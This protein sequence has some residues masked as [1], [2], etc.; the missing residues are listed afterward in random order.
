MLDCFDG[1]IRL[2][3]TCEGG[4][5]VLSLQD[6]GID[7]TLLSHLK[8]SEDTTLGMLSN[9]DS[10]ARAV[11]YNDAV[12]ARMADIRSHTFVDRQRIGDPDQSQTLMT[13]TAATIGGI[14]IETAHPTSNLTIRIGMGYYYGDTAGVTTFTVYDLEDGASVGSYTITAVQ[15]K[16]VSKSIQV[17]LPA[18]RQSKRY[19][20]THDKL[21]YYQVN[22]ASGSCSACGEKGYRH[23]GVTMYGARISDSAAKRYSNL[24]RVS[25]TSGMGITVT[26]ECDHGQWLCEVKNALALPYLYKVGQGILLRGVDNLDRFNSYAGMN[27]EALIERAERYSME[28]NKAMDNTVGKMAVPDDP[29]CFVCKQRTKSIIAIP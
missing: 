19:F 24:S 21:D 20:V 8:G 7:Q 3:A 18:Y 10:W 17:E 15:G 22:V 2:D 27:R 23:G 16:N 9:V 26:V 25:H 12:N 1:L 14:V 6:I 13:G 4:E 29:M 28:Y 5:G 11:V